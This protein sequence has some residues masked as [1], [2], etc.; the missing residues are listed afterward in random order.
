MKG[1]RG[2]LNSRSS[3]TRQGIT[4]S[5]C[6]LSL[7]SAQGIG[8]TRTATWRAI[9]KV[10]WRF[11][12]DRNIHPEWLS[13]TFMRTIALVVSSMKIAML[14]V[15]LAI[16]PSRVRRGR[17]GGLSV[18]GGGGAGSDLTGAACTMVGGRRVGAK[19]GRSR[20]AVSEANGILHNGFTGLAEGLRSRA[21]AGACVR[22][23]ASGPAL[24]VDALVL[25]TGG[26]SS[27]ELRPGVP[28]GPESAATATACGRADAPAHARKPT[29]VVAL[30]RIGLI[31]PRSIA[32]SR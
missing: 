18:G 15:S 19:I 25:T 21:M 17:L 28:R 11:A 26:L 23:S 20:V 10:A 16:A 12:T 7:A 4:T 8:I 6:Q 30:R 24:V 31:C 2:H 29:T 5:R 13:P 32:R 27:P 1:A 14:S 22:G 3:H 9:S